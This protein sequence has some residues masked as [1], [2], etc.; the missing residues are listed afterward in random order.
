[1]ASIIFTFTFIAAAS[2]YAATSYVKRYDNVQSNY[3]QAPLLISQ[4]IQP[5]IHHHQAVPIQ[6]S[7]V[8]IQSGHSG[9]SGYGSQG[10]Y[11]GGY[12]GGYQD[13]Y[14]YPKYKFEYGVKDPHTGDHKSQWEVRDG[15]VVKG[16]YSLDE[17]D[18]TKRVVQYTSDKH[19]GFN[20]V[21]KKI[22]HAHH[23]QVYHQQPYHQGYA[24]GYN[25]IYATGQHLY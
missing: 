25:Q 4:P 20:A 22:G 6:Q 21:V 9:Y 17:A 16:E 1:M 18:G 13:Y 24:N 10:G 7:Y 11:G 2:A 3:H 19:N 8:P 15:D 23:P 12:A 14:S 5:L